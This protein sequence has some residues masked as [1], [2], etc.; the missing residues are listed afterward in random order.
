M[1]TTKLNKADFGKKVNAS[2][3]QI[4]YKGHNIGGAGIMGKFKGRGASKQIQDYSDMAERD[5]SA[6]IQ[7]YGYPH[8]HDAIDKILI[9]IN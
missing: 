4:T 1:E 5:I 6:L 9:M 3:Y 8:M 2:G 7:G